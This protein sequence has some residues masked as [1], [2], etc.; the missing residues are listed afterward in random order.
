[1]ASFHP[2]PRSCIACLACLHTCVH[3]GNEVAARATEDRCIVRISELARRLSARR[4]AQS[5]G[6]Q[7]SRPSDPGLTQSSP[8]LRPWDGYRWT[9]CGKRLFSLPPNERISIIWWASIDKPTDLHSRHNSPYSFGPF[10]GG[11]PSRLYSRRGKLT[12][13]RR[14]GV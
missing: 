1:M 13:N 10:G 3:W 6:I 8:W 4:E 7:C 12:N 5:V 2:A 9:G 14:M 11:W